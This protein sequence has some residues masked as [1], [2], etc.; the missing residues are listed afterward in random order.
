MKVNPEQIDVR[1]VVGSP[2]GEQPIKIVCP[3]HIHRTR[4]KQEDDTGSMAVYRGN[5]H[6]H[7][8]GFHLNRR[9][10]SIVFLLGLW[11]GLGDENS[12]KVAEIV[13]AN[14]SK[15]PELISAHR[16][17]SRPTIQTLEPFIDESFHQFLIRYHEDRMVDE[18]MVKRGMTY[19]TIC[20]YRIGHTGTHFTIPVYDLDNAL[21]TIRYRAD[22][23]RTDTGAGDFRKYEGVR[24]RNQPVLFPLSCLR[25][26]HALKELWI[27]E[28]ELDAV[29]SNQEGACTL[30]VTNGAGSVSR[31]VEM[32][33]FGL[34]RLSVDRYIVATDQDGAGD[35]AASAIQSVL[36]DLGLESVRAR[37][38]GAKDLCEFYSVG[39]S[40]EEIRYA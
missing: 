15:L 20:K 22:E 11:D 12:N 5:V 26:V 30:T 23:T 17:Q 39:G 33:L 37:W 3:P 35:A 27:T 21:I 34:P 25:G 38:R 7:G 10:A 40:R 31:I 24:G 36:S 9:Y 16:V 6:C 4:I 18:L 32:V 29:V 14:R 19:E 2:V 1:L 28:G 13:D 8:C